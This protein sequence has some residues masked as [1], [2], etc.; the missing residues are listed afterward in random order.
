MSVVSTTS[1]NSNSTKVKEAFD[2][3]GDRI[4]AKLKENPLNI[5]PLHLLCAAV[6]IKD[7]LQVI[8]EFDGPDMEDV[9][10]IITSV[11]GCVPLIGPLLQGVF[12]LFWKRAVEDETVTKGFLDNKLKELKEEMIKV[13]DKKISDSEIVQWKEICDSFLKGLYSSC[14]QLGNAISLLKSVLDDGEEPDEATLESI[15]VRLGIDIIGCCESLISF[16]NNPKYIRYT[17]PYYIEALFI[18]SLAYR[19]LDASWYQLK[20]NRRLVSG[21]DSNSKSGRV[22]SYRELIHETMVPGI[23]I[24]A[25]G[26]ND[27]ILKETPE[28]N[29]HIANAPMLLKNDMY[30]YPVPLLEAPL[31]ILPVCKTLSEASAIPTIKIPG[32]RKY[33][34]IYRIDA[35][36]FLPDQNSEDITGSRTV[37]ELDLISG[38]RGLLVHNYYASIHIELPRTA[39]VRFRVFGNYSN[40]CSKISLGFV[41]DKFKIPGFSSDPHEMD[42]VIDPIDCTTCSDN[43]E[44]KS[45][46][47]YTDKIPDLKKIT[48]S[49][50]AKFTMSEKTK[51]LLENPMA[52]M[53][54]GLGGMGGKVNIED[55]AHIH[56]VELIISEK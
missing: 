47:T 42:P 31:K 12:A 27:N 6:N 9:N 3:A 43:T 33:P 11:I 23:K 45:G 34:F 54:M 55:F 41:K 25:K 17:V 22:K 8:M 5:I 44:R 37:P 28:E 7:P 51:K 40:D 20:I 10:I 50:T 14:T 56:F 26:W 15:R 32:D 18:H 38:C 1:N 49:P 48:L 46:F 36:N 29:R 24:I 35:A 53:G 4:A 30:F 21:R 39:T 52:S 16:C 19:Q 13:M 2:G